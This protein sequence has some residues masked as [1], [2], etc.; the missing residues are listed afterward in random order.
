MFHVEHWNVPRF[1]WNIIN[2]NMFHV[3]HSPFAKNMLLRKP[4][5]KDYDYVKGLIKANYK[6]LDL[7]DWYERTVKFS[8]EG[9]I[10]EDWYIIEAA[11]TRVGIIGIAHYPPIY[12]QVVIDEPFRKAGFFADALDLLIFEIDVRFDKQTDIIYLTTLTTNTPMQK[13]AHRR[14]FDFLRTVD[15]PNGTGNRLLVYEL[16][17]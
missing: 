15:S 11:D 16:R 17:R 10:E 1:L 9:G 7:P 8:R 2:A 3:E 6:L 4:T 12:V 5:T 13:A 14:G